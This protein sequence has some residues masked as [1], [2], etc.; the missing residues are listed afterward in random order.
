MTETTFGHTPVSLNVF[1]NCPKCSHRNC[2]EEIR[3]IRVDL[4]V[5]RGSEERVRCKNCGAAM[6]TM[7]AYIG[8][9]VGSEIVRHQDPKY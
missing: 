3:P 7:T 2:L 1:I 9:R 5:F 6:D 8:E 4:A